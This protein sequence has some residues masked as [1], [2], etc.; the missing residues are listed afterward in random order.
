MKHLISA[1]LHLL[2]LIIASIIVVLLAQHAFK[3]S[4]LR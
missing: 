4:F 1:V 3:D 2:I